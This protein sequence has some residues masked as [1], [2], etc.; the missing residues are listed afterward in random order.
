MDCSMPGFSIHHQ[1]SEFTQT[2]VHWGGN[3]IQR[4][5]PLLSP[6]PP[7]FNLSQHQGLFKWVSS[8]HQVAKVLGVWASAS[9]LPM[10]IQDWSPSEWT[11]WIS[12]KSRRLSRV[13]SNTTVQKHQFVSSQLSL[14]SHMTTW[15]TIALARWTLVGKVMCL[16]FNVLSSLVIAFL[17]RSKCL[18]ISWLQSPSAGILEAPNFKPVTVSIVPPSICYELMGPDAI[19]LVV[20]MLSCFFLYLLKNYS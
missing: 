13:F 18:L 4:P 20:W 7:T 16:L 15:K 8:S 10:N 17:L 12:L 19:I 9:V 2:H 14:Q 3:A 6:S 5:H 1:L 11:D